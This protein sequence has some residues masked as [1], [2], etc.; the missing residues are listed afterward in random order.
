MKYSLCVVL[1][2]MILFSTFASTSLAAPLLCK[3]QSKMLRKPTNKNV[4]IGYKL[5]S[6]DENKHTKLIESKLPVSALF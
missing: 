1:T 4:E 2:L 6:V 5:Y 3:K